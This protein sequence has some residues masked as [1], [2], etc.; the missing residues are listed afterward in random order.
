ME[1]RWKRY[2]LVQDRVGH[3]QE[4]SLLSFGVRKV[5]PTQVLK[6]ELLEAL[7]ETEQPKDSTRIAL[8]GI[9]R[10]NL[11]LECYTDAI[12]RLTDKDADLLLGI[13]SLGLRYQ[14]FIDRKRLDFGRQIVP[15]E[16]VFVEVK[17][18]S[19]KLHGIVGYIGELPLLH[20]TIFGVELYVSCFNT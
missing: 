5:T 20:G 6:G 8:A 19:K 4:T 17:G 15:G 7:P 1:N 13:S 3:S 12:A 2:I 11:R 14:T 16:I 10:K 9:E 18:I